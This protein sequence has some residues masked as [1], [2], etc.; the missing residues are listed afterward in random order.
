MLVE[1]DVRKTLGLDEPDAPVFG[2]GGEVV[3]LF[4]AADLAEG[5]R[6][7]EDPSSPLAQAVADLRD[8]Q[9]RMLERSAH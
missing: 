7:L 6:M 5:E 1:A 8:Q 4:D 3:S 9:R 2:G